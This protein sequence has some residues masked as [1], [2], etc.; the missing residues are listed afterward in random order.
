MSVSANSIGIRRNTHIHSK[1]KKFV[2]RDMAKPRSKSV[3]VEVVCVNHS[4]SCQATE[5]LPGR[6][7]HTL[8]L[9]TGSVGI[10]DRRSVIDQLKSAFLAHGNNIIATTRQQ[11]RWFFR[12]DSTFSVNVNF[13]IL[14]S[15]GD[16]I[17]DLTLALQ[18]IKQSFQRNY[19]YSIRTMQ[20]TSMAYSSQ[21]STMNRCW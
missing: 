10:L 1:T 11:V 19:E 6:A 12:V 16:S 13:R 17:I 21:Y 15:S 9:F 14:T 8:A 5:R 20:N 7:Q 3:I 4:S 2:P 18:L